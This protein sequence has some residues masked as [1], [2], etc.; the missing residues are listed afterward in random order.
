MLLC[1][2]NV[3]EWFL[4]SQIF[5]F[6]LLLCRICSLCR[7]LL[8]LRLP[9]TTFCRSL[10]LFLFF[11][12]FTAAA[13]FSQLVGWLHT[14]YFSSFSLHF[15]DKMGNKYEWAQLDGFISEKIIP[16]MLFWY[17]LGDFF[18]FVLWLLSFCYET[19]FLFLSLWQYSVVQS[20]FCLLWVG[21]K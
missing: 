21:E 7:L 14:V 18:F 12:S 13:S 8:R 17:F 6:I 19:S 5:P 15:W 11:F 1:S 2:M 9:T 16:K 3:R 10:F 20:G 4:F